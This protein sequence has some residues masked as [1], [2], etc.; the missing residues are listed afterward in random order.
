M[1]WKKPS[2]LAYIQERTQLKSTLNKGSFSTYHTHAGGNETCFSQ[3]P[4]PFGNVYRAGDALFQGRTALLFGY[5]LEK[6]VWGCSLPSFVTVKNWE[7]LNR[8]R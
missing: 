6:H 2:E 7:Q 1:N 5:T 4:E 8:L 3:A